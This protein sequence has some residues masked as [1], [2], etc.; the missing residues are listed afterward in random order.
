MTTTRTIVGPEAPL[1]ADLHL[2]STYGRAE[3]VLDILIRSIVPILLALVAGGILLL[4]LGVNPI[5]FY[6]NIFSRGITC[7]CG[8]GVV[9][10]WNGPLIRMLA[11]SMAMNDIISVVMISFV[12]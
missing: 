12:P 5:T 8:S 11:R 6:G 2:P 4:A 1:A 7:V 9:G 3:H 10:S